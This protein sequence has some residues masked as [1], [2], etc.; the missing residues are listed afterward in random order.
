MGAN[1][2]HRD[3]G[4]HWVRR[5]VVESAPDVECAPAPIEV[6]RLEP[7]VEPFKGFNSPPGRF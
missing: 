2:E 4:T 7:K 5:E 1:T 6:K 3:N